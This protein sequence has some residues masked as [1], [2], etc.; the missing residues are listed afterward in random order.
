AMSGLLSFCFFARAKRTADR[1][2]ASEK[3]LDL[4]RQSQ[5]NIQP[6]HRPRRRRCDQRPRGN[7]AGDDRPRRHHGALS[8]PD[9]SSRIA[10]EDRVRSEEGIL[11][12]NDPA[13]PTSVAPQE[14]PTPNPT[15]MRRW[16]GRTFPAFKAR[17]S[18]IGMVQETVFPTSSIATQ[19]F[20]EGNLSFF[21]RCSSMN[22]FAWWK[23]NKS[24]SSIRSL[25]SAN[26]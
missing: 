5:G 8:N 13:W 18:A 24:M 9:H 17:L 26:S 23:M 10:A 19:N 1:L 14:K 7:A 20:S 12:Y 2:H 4:G 16:P 21:R 15:S 3:I 22:L 6:R 25:A 11:L